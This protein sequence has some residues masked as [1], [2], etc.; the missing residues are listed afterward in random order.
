MTLSLQTRVRATPDTMVQELEG[1]SVLLN[2]ASEHY[3][4]L[5]EVGTRMWQALTTADNVQAAHTML[6]SEYDVSPDVLRQDLLDLVQ[7][8]VEHGLVSLSE[9]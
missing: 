5:D 8:L 2:L 4:G 9:E 1:E 7:Q 3:F 6:L